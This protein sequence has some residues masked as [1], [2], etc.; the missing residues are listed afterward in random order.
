MTIATPEP[1]VTRA[2]LLERAAA[3]IPML[4][5]REASTE[6]L[7]TLPV[8]TVEAFLDAGFYR[9]LQPKRFG[10]YEQDLRT[11]CDVMINISRGCGSS[12]WV[13]CLTSA[14]V[15]HMAACPEE[16]QVEMYGEDGDFR[17][18]LILAPQGTAAPVE[19]GY[20][21][22]GRWNYGSGAEHS[23]WLTVSAIVP[24]ENKSSPPADVLLAFVHCDDYEIHDNWFALG[25][26]GT[27]SKQAV[28]ADVFVPNRRVISQPKWGQGSAPGFGVHENPFYRTPHMGVFFAEIAS[29]CIGLAESAMDVFGERAQTKVNPFPPFQTMAHDQA[30]QRRVGLAR[31]KI[32]TAT[33][34]LAAIIDEQERV[35]R[36]AA[37][38]TLDFQQQDTVRGS[39][40]VQEVGE[41]CYAAIELLF[42]RSGTSA[43]QTGE[44]LERIY[45]DISTARTHY[46][47]DGERTAENWGALYF[48]LDE[49]SPD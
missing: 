15:F 42:R 32:D 23:N 43:A 20:R 47:M 11:F 22:T 34:A 6:E 28:L 39:M 8:E 45:R 7:R 25:L 31:A 49:H 40:R 35:T 13:L 17:S 12:G 41:L 4:R 36:M 44:H 48:G 2:V 30:V 21:V 5:A 18:P 37:E 27:G 10:G 24:G 16:G 38:G 46:L 19:G 1:D 3:M 14:H 29:I 9:I 33:A 26:R